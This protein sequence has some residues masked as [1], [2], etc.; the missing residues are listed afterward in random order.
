MLRRLRRPP[1]RACALLLGL[2]LAAAAGPAAQAQGVYRVVGP[3]GSVTFTDRPPGTAARVEPLGRTGAAAVSPALPPALREA[4]ARFPVLLYTVPQ[5]AP[6]DRGRQLLRARGIPHQERVADPQTDAET[7]LRVL[8]STDAPG[9]TVGA[10]VLRGFSEDEWH[11][12]L[13]LAG[14]PRQSRLPANR[15]HPAPL[16]LVA[17][18]APP[19]AEPAPFALPLPLPAPG[20]FRF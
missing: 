7:W 5:C 1:L 8:G 18:P 6:C 4:V 10:Q 13:D 20:G 17:R 12:T 14:Y 11:T 16:P 19:A 15:P 3:D 2:L 9:L